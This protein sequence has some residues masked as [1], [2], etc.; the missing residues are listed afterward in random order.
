MGVQRCRRERQGKMARKAFVYLL[1]CTANQYHPLLDTLNWD[2]IPMIWDPQWH[3]LRSCLSSIPCFFSW[4]LTQGMACSSF[5]SSSPAHPAAFLLIWSRS[6]PLGSTQGKV[7]ELWCDSHWRWAESRVQPPVHTP[8]KPPPPSLSAE[9]GWHDFSPFQ[10]CC[11][12]LDPWSIQL[13]HLQASIQA[14]T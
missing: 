8:P 6:R 5:P 12:D 2:K 3:R 7:M 10:G 9:T 1:S 4:S 11:K 13:V 14:V